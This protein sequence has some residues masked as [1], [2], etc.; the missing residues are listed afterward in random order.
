M[1]IES[2]NSFQVVLASGSPRRYQLLKLIHDS[3]QVITPGID[4]DGSLDSPVELAQEI[5]A[6]KGRVVYQRVYQKSEKPLLTIAADTIVVAAGRVLGKPEDRQDAQA[7]LTSLSGKQ[8]QVVTAVDLLITNLKDRGGDELALHYPFWVQTE[9][10]FVRLD[11]K[12]LARYLDSGEWSDKAGAY[13]IQGAAAPFV[14]KIDGSYTN[15]VGLPLAELRDW[16]N[17]ALQDAV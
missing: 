5:A 8:H 12:M 6:L 10:T 9:V 1:L 14:A 16:I 13:G 7:M 2:V 11:E 3:F 17:R 15:V 4:E